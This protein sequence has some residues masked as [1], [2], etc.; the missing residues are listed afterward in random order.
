MRNRL[1]NSAESGSGNPSDVFILAESKANCE[2][3]PK[4]RFFDVRLS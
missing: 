2:Y 1:R 3:V 4:P